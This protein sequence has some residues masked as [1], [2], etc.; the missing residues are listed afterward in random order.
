MFDALIAVH[1]A[2]YLNVESGGRRTALRPQWNGQTP[3]DLNMQVFEEPPE[4]RVSLQYGARIL[5]RSTVEGWRDRL[6]DLLDAAVADPSTQVG[7]L[8]AALR[9]E[10]DLEFDL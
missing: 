10:P 4:L 5:R 7:T 6:L 1:S 8:T 9:P 2:R 3:F